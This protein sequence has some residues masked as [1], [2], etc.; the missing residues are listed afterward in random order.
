MQESCFKS[1]GG[2]GLSK[3]GLSGTVQLTIRVDPYA[4]S[5]SLS[6]FHHAK[7]RGSSGFMIIHDAYVTSGNYQLIPD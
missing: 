6:V 5:I 2:A 3:T 7:S 4:K 1:V